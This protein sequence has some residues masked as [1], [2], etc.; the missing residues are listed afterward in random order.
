MRKIVVAYFQ[1]EHEAMETVFDRATRTSS[2]A[3]NLFG[4][5]VLIA[6]RAENP[7]SQK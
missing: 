7:G 2:L 5:F 4:C 1:Q 6:R 3:T